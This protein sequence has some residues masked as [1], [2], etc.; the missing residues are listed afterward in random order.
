MLV[1][2][3]LPFIV[4]LPLISYT[5]L[6]EWPR[7]LWASVY[8][9]AVSFPLLRSMFD[10]LLP[11]RLGFKVTP[12]GVLSD[13]RSFDWASSRGLLI[14]AAIT[15]AAI[16]KGVAEF[17]VFGIEKDAY[18][19]NLGW[20]SFNLFF[21]LLA[22]LVAWEKPQRRAEERIAKCVPIELKAEDFS[23]RARTF[24]ISLSGVSCVLDT[25]E[26]IPRLVTIVMHDA[27]PITCRARLVYHEP[28]SGRSSRAA[29]A[30]LD[31]DPDRRNKMILNLFADPNTWE[32][33]HATN[34]RSNFVMAWHLAL[35]L[36]RAIRP[37]RRLRR[38][39]I[40]R[41]DWGILPI[42][43]GDDPQG[44]SSRIPRLAA[45]A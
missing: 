35:G 37:V 16:V 17:F 26:P 40:R 42:R 30:W 12:K 34:T 28:T 15:L 13:R 41:R 27:H 7:L 14:A 9:M 24:D 3:L 5:L 4:F 33:A 45:L 1:A 10:L 8:E 43:I 18:F 11:K 36:V 20:A 21:L 38:M 44:C 19:F 29:F 22:L 2:Y 39:S 32:R 6:P 23:L 25:R 31:L